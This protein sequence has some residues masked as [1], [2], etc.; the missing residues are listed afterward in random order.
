MILARLSSAKARRTAVTFCITAGFL[1]VISVITE[2]YPQAI[3]L[4]KIA[5][6]PPAGGSKSLVLVVPPQEAVEAKITS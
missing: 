1:I 5:E 4:V 2:I 3:G 6:I